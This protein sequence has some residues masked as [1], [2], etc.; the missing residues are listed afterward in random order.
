MTI[1]RVLV[2]GSGGRE[3]ALAWRL[4]RDPGQPRVFVA[5]GNDG[6]ARAFERLDVSDTDPAAV[7]RAAR[8]A[9][10]DLVVVGPESALAAG[11]SDALVAAGLPVFGAS[12]AAAQ[13]ESS[14][15]FAKEVMREAGVPTAR[16]FAC[17]SEAEAD[18]A[19]AA[20]GAPHVVKA[21]GLAAGKGVLVTADLGA[22][23][24]FA[25][26]C[27][28]GGRF[29]P[30]ARVVIEEY[31]QGE[32]ASLIA[33]CDGT[34]HLLLPPA[35][36]HKRAFDGDA[37]PNTGGMGA[38]APAPAV[39]AAVERATSEQVV[40]PM[41]HAMAARGTPYRGALYVGVMVRS[42]DARGEHPV[43]VVEF[44]ARFGDPE[45]QAMLPLVSGDFAGLLA[46]AARGA[47]EPERVARASGAAVTVALVDEGYP[48]RTLGTGTIA[49]LDALEGRDGL[50]VFHAGTRR[51]VD[52]WR[53]KGGRAA[54]VTAL[55]RDRGDACE[56][57]YA[58]CAT[59]GGAHWRMRRDI[60]V[61]PGVP[62]ATQHDEGG[63]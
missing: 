38:I 49:G 28:G 25:R 60:G 47:L 32:E 9:Q 57:A 6:M 59:L 23:R 34:R 27:L 36:D 24:A 35:R 41:L 37:G 2:L 14:K 13:L 20:L 19:F 53:V 29:G 43:A 4:A 48:E 51:E 21:D 16:A 11:V 3:H 39:S 40:T 15:W 54:Y 17:T 12:R 61:G 26:E 8:D 42:G 45:T 22:A 44:N 46:G 1:S 33:I 18:A 55:G 30:Q 62:A 7:V 52:A 31:L 58:A 5:P 56:R 50:F 63:Q 10:V